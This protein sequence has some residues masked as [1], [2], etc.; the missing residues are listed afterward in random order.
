MDADYDIFEIVAVISDFWLIDAE[1]YQRRYCTNHGQPLAP[2]YYVVNWPESILVRRFNK[3][4]AFHGPFKLRQ[5]A[6]KVRDWMHKERESV[7]I[8]ASEIL[9]VAAPKSSRL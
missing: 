4:A 7:L 8:R 3:H 2:G 9:S 1:S 5:E 6:Q